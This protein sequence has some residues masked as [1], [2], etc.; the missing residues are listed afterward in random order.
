MQTNNEISPIGAKN[1]TVNRPVLS[2]DYDVPSRKHG[3][4]D[5]VVNL[6][7]GE[8]EGRC[9]LKKIDVGLLETHC[10]LDPELCGQGYGTM[11]YSAAIRF[12][13][14]MGFRVCSSRHREMPLAARRVWKSRGLNKSFKIV[15]GWERFY[16]I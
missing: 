13:K 11:M 5:F 3:F 14:E 1:F 15:R 9:C 8:F 12:A 16:V 7:V 10:R 6:S 2:I 4:Y